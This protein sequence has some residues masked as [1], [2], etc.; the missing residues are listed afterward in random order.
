MTWIDVIE[1]ADARG[2]LRAVYQRVRAP[3]GTIDNILKAHSLRPHTLT[4]HMTLYK[5]VLHHPGNTL[6]T[7]FLEA[8]G[9]R[10]SY[11]NRCEYCVA[12][13]AAGLGRLLADP[14]RSRAIVS[15]LTAD[16]PER[17]FEGKELALLRYA[18]LLTT[19]PAELTAE[20][21][22]ALHD[23]GADDGEILEVNQVTAYFAYANRTVLG[24]GVTTDGDVLGR[25]PDDRDDPD[26]WSHG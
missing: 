6:P 20:D 24:L 17:A 13:H 16:A 9:I 23:A 22:L 26:N 25:S 5:N 10:V 15:A 3:D 19:V 18:E 8:V 11:L 14:A 2:P 7:W 1:L 12:H 4:G 21:L